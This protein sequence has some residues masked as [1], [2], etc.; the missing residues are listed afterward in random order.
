MERTAIVSRPSYTTP[1]LVRSHGV[2]HS[3][4]TYC[5]YLEFTVCSHSGPRRAGLRFLRA[6]AAIFVWPQFC[7]YRLLRPKARQN[8]KKTANRS[9]G[10]VCMMWCR[11]EWERTNGGVC[12]RVGRLR[13]SVRAVPPR[14]VANSPHLA[15]SSSGIFSKKLLCGLAVLEEQ[16]HGR[17]KYFQ[18]Q[19]ASTV[20]TWYG[21]LGSGSAVSVTCSWVDQRDLISGT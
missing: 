15:L 2:S 18:L 4:C 16:Y 19:T 13:I 8:E 9:A 14:Q 5:V 1:S 6:T 11:T 12:A 20:S 7:W 3:C 17:K 21:F 10:C